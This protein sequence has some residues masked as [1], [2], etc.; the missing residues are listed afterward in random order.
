MQKDIC[1]S[2]HRYFV[3]S[4]GTVEGMDVIKIWAVVVCTVCKDSHLIEHLMSKAATLT[5]KG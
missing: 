1:Q 4:E 5:L 3:A 2:Y